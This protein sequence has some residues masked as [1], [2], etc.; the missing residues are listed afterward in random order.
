MSSVKCSGKD[1]LKTLEVSFAVA[2]TTTPTDGLAPLGVGSLLW[3]TFIGEIWKKIPT[4]SLKCTWRCHLQYVNHTCQ[5]S[6][7]EKKSVSANWIGLAFAK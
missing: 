5:A 3:E 1:E 7:W 2:T 6:M 4:C